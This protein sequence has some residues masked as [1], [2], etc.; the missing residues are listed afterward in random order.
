MAEEDR[1]AK[2]K[3]NTTARKKQKDAGSPSQSSSK[4]PSKNA[5]KF[6]DSSSYSPN[7]KQP[8]S[9][10]KGATS[11]VPSKDSRNTTELNSPTSPTKPPAKTFRSASSAAP[12]P[13]PAGARTPR[14]TVSTEEKTRAAEKPSRQT[15]KDEKRV[16]SLWAEWGWSVEPKASRSHEADR[17]DSQSRMSKSARDGLDDGSYYA[18]DLDSWNP[19]NEFGYYGTYG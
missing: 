16:K 7:E 8:K 9:L 2:K 1:K 19:Q 11:P 6:P 13:G 15:A 17:M 5:V 4:A 10:K 14:D 12:S 18:S 3:G